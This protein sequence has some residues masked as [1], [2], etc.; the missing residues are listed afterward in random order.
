MFAKDVEVAQA[1]ASQLARVGITATLQPLE[2]ARLLAERNEGD[3]D[4]TTLIWPMAWMPTNLFTFT[5]D[6]SYPD[7]KLSPKWGASPPELI[8]ARALMKDA[9]GA[10][11]VEQMGTKFGELNR[12]VHD[13]AFW[14]FVHTVDDIWGI[15]KDTAW[16]PYPTNYPPLY[17]YWATVGKQAPA[18]TTVPLVAPRVAR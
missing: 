13:E 17:D 14:L 9:V 7:A 15:Q 18:D 4:V 11:T 1:V 2:R 8:Q 3:Y 16:R 6:T 5:L 12:L 10:S